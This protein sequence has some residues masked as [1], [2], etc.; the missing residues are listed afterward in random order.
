MEGK[1]AKTDTFLDQKA[2]ASRLL[3]RMKQYKITKNRYFD[4]LQGNAALNF[5]KHHSQL[6]DCL[7]NATGERKVKTLLGNVCKE[8]AEIVSVICRAQVVSSGQIQHVKN[9][10][11]R[12][13]WAWKYGFQSKGKLGTK[14]CYIKH[15]VM[16]WGLACCVG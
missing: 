11:E 10:F 15:I 12:F 14:L 2:P 5:C 3:N 7:S 4:Q 1:L 13:L 16:F 8:W 6:I 9:C